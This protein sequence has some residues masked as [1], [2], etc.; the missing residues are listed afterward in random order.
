[1][2]MRLQQMRHLRCE[3]HIRLALRGGEEEDFERCDAVTKQ[4]Q[5]KQTVSLHKVLICLLPFSSPHGTV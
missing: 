4:Q 3:M 5:E 1:M 2:P